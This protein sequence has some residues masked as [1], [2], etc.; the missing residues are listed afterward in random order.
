M[1]LL[2]P[3]PPGPAAAS[4]SG[5]RA[6]E[7]EHHPFCDAAGAAR[8][9]SWAQRLQHTPMVKRCASVASGLRQAGASGLTSSGG[10]CT[11]AH[12]CTNSPLDKTERACKTS[13]QSALDTQCRHVFRTCSSP[14]TDLSSRPAN[15]VLPGHW[16]LVGLE[17][18]PGGSC[19]HKASGAASETE[20]CITFTSNHQCVVQHFRSLRHAGAVPQRTQLAR[21]SPYPG[22]SSLMGAYW[23]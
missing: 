4:P 7:E 17:P 2:H 22:A 5:V 6:S 12:R 20:I 23:S 8:A 19:T 11:A 21:Q 18:Y 16:K 14:Q 15:S 10:E 13:N 3:A 1:V 9:R